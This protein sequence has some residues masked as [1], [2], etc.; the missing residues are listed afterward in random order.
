LKAPP[1]FWPTLRAL[2]AGVYAQAG[3]AEEGLAMVDE[4]L[5]I[6]GRGAGTT[7]VPEFQLLKG[8]LLL[9]SATTPIP[10][11][12]SSGRSTAPG[13]WTYGCRSC[14]QRSGSAGSDRS[15]T[16]GNQ[17]PGCAPSTGASP[18][19]SPRPI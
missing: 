7:M 8:D 13:V 17:P 15:G 9:A 19:A 16:V 4:A 5:E 10:S 14:E 11:P 3:R 1:V 6:A 2:E 12:G 18:K